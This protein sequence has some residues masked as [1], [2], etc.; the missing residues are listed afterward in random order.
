MEGSTS[1]KKQNWSMVYLTDEDTKKLNELRYKFGNAGVSSVF[2]MALRE[3]YHQIIEKKRKGLT[4]KRIRGVGEQKHRVA[5]ISPQ[6]RWA[7]PL[8][9]SRTVTQRAIGYALFCR[10]L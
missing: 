9:F 1:T 10:E 8:S 5:V 2:T 7:L 4:F 3:F 6:L